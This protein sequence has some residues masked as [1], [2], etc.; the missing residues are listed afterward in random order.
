MAASR[1]M[2][3]SPRRV[4]AVPARTS[5]A[6]VLAQSS[7]SFVH[8]LARYVRRWKLLLAVCRILWRLGAVQQMLVA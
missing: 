5:I 3:A 6:A 2:L 8:S 4:A 7:C 1:L